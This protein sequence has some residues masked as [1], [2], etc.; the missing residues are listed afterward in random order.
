MPLLL[1]THVAY[2]TKG[3]TGA[4]SEFVAYKFIQALKDNPINKYAWVPIGNSTR[5]LENSNRAEAFSWFGEIAGPEITA[6]I[7]SPRVFVPVPNS[8]CVVGVAHAR[9]ARLVRAI[10]P[11]AGGAIWDGLRWREANLKAQH[12]GSRDPRVLFANLTVVKTA[13]AGNCI[14]VDDVTTSGGH[15]QAAAARLRQ[16]GMAPLLAIAAGQ[17]VH[18]P[19]P[20]PFGWVEREL[21]DF[22]P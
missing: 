5:K 20:K 14:L 15:F 1:V 13:A 9:T 19:V 17:T 16:V 10:L 7:S 3:Q 8:D 11:Y 2:L 6:R 21:D 22:I 4:Q 18:E 12:G